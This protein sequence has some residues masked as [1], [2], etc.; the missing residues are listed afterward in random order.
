MTPSVTIPFQEEAVE[1]DQI[2]FL[3]GPIMRVDV[4]KDT[5]MEEWV[6]GYKDG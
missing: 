6:D 1:G 4:W 2:G 3:I 5:W